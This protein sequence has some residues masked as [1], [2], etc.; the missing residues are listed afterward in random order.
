[1]LITVGNKR[2]SVWIYY[3]TKHTEYRYSKYVQTVLVSEILIL[4]T[5]HLITKWRA[6]ETATCRLDYAT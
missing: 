4:F 2:R 3:H 6:N 1:M 5:L